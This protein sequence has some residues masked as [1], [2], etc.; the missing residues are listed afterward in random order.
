M[1]ERIGVE[2]DHENYNAIYLTQLALAI[3]NHQA[4]L[5]ALIQFIN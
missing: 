1:S 2:I 4:V 3:D 5:V